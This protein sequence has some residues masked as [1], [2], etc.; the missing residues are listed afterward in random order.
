MLVQRTEAHNFRALGAPYRGSHGH[1]EADTQGPDRGQA[2]A[3]TRDLPEHTRQARHGRFIG[4]AET[5][6]TNHTADRAGV[7]C[8]P[9]ATAHRDRKATPARSRRS[10]GRV[11]N[12]R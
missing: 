8:A 9:R 7:K 3:T 12:A 4:C 5:H 6:R 2:S 1:L 11:T 10:A